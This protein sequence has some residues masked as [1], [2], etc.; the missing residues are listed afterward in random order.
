[1]LTLGKAHKARC[2]HSRHW[3]RDRIFVIEAAL[4]A[5]LGHVYAVERNVEAVELIKKNA[6]KFQ[7]E[8]M[9]M[10]PGKAPSALESVPPCDVI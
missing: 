2:G 7:V 10:L 4:L 5:P 9:T 1:M 6:E 8:N 3:S